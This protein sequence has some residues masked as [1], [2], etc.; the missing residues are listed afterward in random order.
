MLVDARASVFTRHACCRSIDL[1][2]LRSCDPGLHMSSSAAR[3]RSAQALCRRAFASGDLDLLERAERSR[4]G[5]RLRNCA[6]ACAVR[7]RFGSPS[8]HFVTK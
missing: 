1:D 8:E 6:N 3:V 2:N 7:Q 4:R 5:T